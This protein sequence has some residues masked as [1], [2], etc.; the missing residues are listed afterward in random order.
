MSTKTSTSA[1]AT[2]STVQRRTLP[3]GRP[4]PNYVD[5]CDEDPPIAG[6]KF[7]CLS[8][9]SPETVLKKRETFLFHQFVR[10]WDMNK[11]ME[12]FSEFMNF[13]AFKYSLN[14]ENV[15]ADFKDFVQEEETRL[16]EAAAPVEDDYKNF[17]DKN[18]DRL[19]LQFNRENDFQT[20]V[21]GIKV[22]GSFSTQEEA[23]R[24][25]KKLRERD[26]SHDIYLGQVGIWMPFEPNAYKTG[27]VEFLEPEL[28]RLHEEKI[29]NEAKAKQ[30]F[31]ERIKAAKRKAIEDNIEKARK[32]G[33]KLTQTI[34][35]Q[36]NLVGVNTMN[37]DDRE[38]ADPKEQEAHMKEV[39][40]RANHAAATSSGADVEADAGPAEKTENNA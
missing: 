6:Q 37:F 36:G 15:L 30:E 33:N 17:L 12:K 5:L 31:D 28:N 29:K 3:D 11:S 26:P 40:A 1:S 8:F 38:V 2:N 13:L 25:C 32:S 34:D 22:R 9:I 4:N 35:D 23:E 14:A 27:K 18:E 16:K 24:N 21:R 20:S 19:N 10:Q 39:L 7:V